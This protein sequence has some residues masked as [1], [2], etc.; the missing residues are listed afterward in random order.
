M[1]FL[2][3]R[4]FNVVG[5]GAGTVGRGWS[6]AH[7]DQLQFFPVDHQ[8]AFRFVDPG[9]VIQACYLIPKF[10][11]GKCHIN[12]GGLSRCANNG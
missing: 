6:T 1:E 9:Q 12:G 8:D 10:V 4:H 5:K 3:V 11:L 7:L 2:W